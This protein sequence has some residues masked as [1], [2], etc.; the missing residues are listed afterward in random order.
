MSPVSL[1]AK[2]LSHSNSAI[3]SV[4]YNR[5]P[6][7]V[8]STHSVQCNVLKFI[9]C[10]YNRVITSFFILLHF[11]GEKHNFSVCETLTWLTKH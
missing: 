7:A 5:G 8:S 4:S 1:E 6:P 2:Y 10:I 3:I 9:Y 11:T